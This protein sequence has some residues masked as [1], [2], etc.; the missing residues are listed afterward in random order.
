MNFEIILSDTKQYLLLDVKYIQTELICYSP[1]M[2]L[3]KFHSKYL[4]KR[5]ILLTFA[6]EKLNPFFYKSNFNL[7]A[8]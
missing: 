6:G 4:V 1:I 8:L 7:F 5:L 2:T 3:L